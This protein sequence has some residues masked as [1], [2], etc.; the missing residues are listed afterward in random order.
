MI[1][2]SV[3]VSAAPGDLGKVPSPFVLAAH[4]RGARLTAVWPDASP[5]DLSTCYGEVAGVLERLPED[6]EVVD[7]FTGRTETRAE[8]VARLT[9]ELTIHEVFQWRSFEW[10]GLRFWRILGC[11]TFGKGDLLVEVE[12]DISSDA[13]E[14]ML[15]YLSRY[16]WMSERK[17]ELGDAM[18]FGFWLVSIASASLYDEPFWEAAKEA[19]G[20]QELAT[21]FD[22]RMVT[23]GP[24]FLIECVEMSMGGE[25]DW[26]VGVSR[27][28]R[29]LEAQRATHERLRAIF[30]LEEA[31]ALKPPFGQD[32]AVVGTDLEGSEAIFAQRRP[33]VNDED[34]GW[35]FGSADADAGQRQ[36]GV[37]TVAHLVDRIPG[38]VRYLALPPG[39]VVAHD[40]EGFW[41]SPPDAA[42]D[43]NAWLDV[44]ADPSPP[45]LRTEVPLDP[46]K[47]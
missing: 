34:S 27:T 9:G 41:V 35:H 8:A 43:G 2:I 3:A 20:T 39:W 26:V 28:L 45:W 6:T 17:L 12:D 30:H 7:L 32:P 44:E 37:S 10:E 25:F 16:R 14:E 18:P 47:E 15:G 23:P 24:E 33:P 31:P 19:L 21:A 13:L 46:S 1:Q 22:A 29:T 4:P 5:T 36:L 11:Y 38:L 40:A 42:A